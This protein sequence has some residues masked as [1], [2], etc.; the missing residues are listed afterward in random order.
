[1]AIV[2]AGFS[3]F[4]DSRSGDSYQP[5]ECDDILF[6]TLENNIGTSVTY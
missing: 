3:N 2:N 5:N 4:Q 1:V 6:L